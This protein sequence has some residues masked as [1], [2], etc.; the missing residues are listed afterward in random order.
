MKRLKI[1]MTK[2]TKQIKLSNKY[3]NVGY[4]NFR[5]YCNDEY[6]GLGLIGVVQVSLSWY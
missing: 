3:T 6:I 4:Y 5:I 1:L 2:L